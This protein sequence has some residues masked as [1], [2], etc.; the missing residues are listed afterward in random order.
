MLIARVKVVKEKPL[1]PCLFE[2]H[3][4]NLKSGEYVYLH[5]EINPKKSLPDLSSTI[6]GG[7]QRHNVNHLY[8]REIIFDTTSKITS[9]K[10]LKITK[11]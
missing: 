8:T 7:F 3:F 10:I 9:Q 11:I 6:R 2:V 5:K 1:F 4:K